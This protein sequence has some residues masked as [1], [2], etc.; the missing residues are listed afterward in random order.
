M[1]VIL[2]FCLIGFYFPT[3]VGAQG[4]FSTESLRK[5]FFEKAD[6]SKD[7]A[8]LKNS[9]EGSVSR[10]ADSESIWIR[11]EN[12]Q[13]Y[14]RW[15]YKLSQNSL[16]RDRQEIRVWLSYVS[17]KRSVSRG[18]DY[19]QWFREKKVPYE[20]GK[21][22]RNR[23]V[24][25]DYRLIKGIYRLV[26]MVWAADVS[27]N[28]WLVQNGWSFYLIEKGDSPYHNDFVAAEKSAQDRQLGLWEPAN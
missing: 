23:R 28:L 3:S 20:I 5:K 27:I 22:F 18:K 2:F 25:V 11:I 6:Q 4:F 9:F 16:N 26:G 8:R 15:T 12:R 19:N 10:V 7:P 14:L 1:R 13:D 21:N 24:R 17:P